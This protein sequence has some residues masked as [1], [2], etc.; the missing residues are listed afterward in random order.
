MGGYNST[1]YCYACN[2]RL[3]ENRIYDKL[4]DNEEPKCP[5]CGSELVGEI[6]EELYDK[7]P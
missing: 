7:L 2:Q 4:K 6:D 1:W 3:L 5:D